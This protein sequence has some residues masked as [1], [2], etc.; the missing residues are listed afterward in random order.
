MLL[1]KATRLQ[2]QLEKECQTS[3]TLWAKLSKQQAELDSKVKEIKDMDTKNK[4]LAAECKGSKTEIIKLKRQIDRL[5]RGETDLIG[6]QLQLETEKEKT[7]RQSLKAR[8]ETDLLKT[9]AVSTIEVTQRK[10]NLKQKSKAEDNQRKKLAKEQRHFA[11]LNNVCNVGG[12][13]GGDQLMYSNTPQARVSLSWRKCHTSHQIATP[14]R[15]P[16]DPMW[17]SINAPPNQ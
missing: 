12:P 11:L 4:D 10:E 13:P 9:K 5:K 1:K 7:V 17:S 2:T 14:R 3:T 16:C 15:T 6:K 8:A